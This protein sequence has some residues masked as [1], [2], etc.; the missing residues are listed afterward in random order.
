MVDF[1]EFVEAAESNP[2]SAYHQLGMLSNAASNAGLRSNAPE[3]KAARDKI[4]AARNRS[5][6]E[7]RKATIAARRKRP[8]IID[9]VA[10][11]ASQAGILH[12]AVDRNLDLLASE[13]DKVPDG[14]WEE[15]V[16]AFRTAEAG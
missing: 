15:W 9:T 6:T 4:E 8:Q 16:E 1:S 12:L 10:S 7:K 11:N 13:A 3:V 14:E 2:D 5:A